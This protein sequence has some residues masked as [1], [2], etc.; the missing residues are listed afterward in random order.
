MNTSEEIKLTDVF[1]LMLLKFEKEEFPTLEEYDP[2]HPT[3]VFNLSKWYLE[4]EDIAKLL[5]DQYVIAGNLPENQDVKK[6]AVIRA[7]RYWQT[8]FSEDFRFVPELGFKL[9]DLQSLIKENGDDKLLDYLEMDQLSEDRWGRQSSLKTPS[10]IIRRPSLGFDA[11]SPEDLAEVLASVDYKLFRRI[12]FREFCVYAQMARLSENTTRIEECIRLF[13]GVTVWVVCN[14]LRE[15]TMLKRADIIEKFIDTAEKLYE[16][17]SYNTMLAVVGGLNHFSVKRLYQTWSKVDKAKRENLDKWTNFFSMDSNYGAYRQRV[18]QIENDVFQQP[19]LGILMKDLVAV[20]GQLKNYTDKE[21]TL[22]SMSKYKKLWQQLSK[23]RQYQIIPPHFVPNNEFMSVFRAAVT[24]S[25]MSD[26]ALEELSQIRE[27]PVGDNKSS[28]TRKE[29]KLAKFADWAS[30]NM[31][32]LDVDTLKKHVAKMVDSVF[33]VYDTD[34]SGYISID[35]FQSISSNFPFIESFSVLDRDKDGVI[36]REEMMDYFLSANTS[37]REIFKHNFVEHT[38]IATAYCEHCKGVLKGIV[39]QGV[40]CKDCGI[41]CHKH[42]KDYVVVDCRKH[43]EKKSKR[44]RRQLGSTSATNGEYDVDDELSLKE[45]LK[46]AEAA[47]DALS[48]E[49]AELH[50]KLAEAN[51]KIQ[52]LNGYIATIR[53]HTIGFIL[54]QMNTLQPQMDTAV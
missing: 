39:R 5:I 37:L 31:P 25:H 8:Q 7:F 47:R 6:E 17:H 36:S 11:T 12:P 38:F 34:Q 53:Q 50:A 44:H 23:L 29:S 43:N 3:V 2:S 15:Y 24:Q 35:E 30:G 48:A 26:D 10:H 16:I 20:D 13:N 41:S 32:Q 51:A 49:N 4:P 18:Q 14:V 54:E 22:L 1:Q 46:R 28:P 52:Q 33:R 45:R 27:P 21:K 19:V 9:S 40:R 42:C